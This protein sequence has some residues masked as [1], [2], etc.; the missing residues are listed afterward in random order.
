MNDLADVL[1]LPVM[2]SADDIR[3]IFQSGPSAHWHHEDDGHHLGQKKPTNLPWVAERIAGHVPP[4]LARRMDS[5]DPM[6]RY[7]FLQQGRGEVFPH[8]DDDY[9]GP[10]G[11]RALCSIILH[12]NDDCSGGETI[13]CG[14]TPA[15]YVPTGA[16]LVFPHDRLHEGRR[17]DKG[18]KLILKTDLFMMQMAEAS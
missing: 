14:R 13:F 6:M 17:V 8:R 4:A 15:P 7:Y 11:S 18:D 2:F 12:L 16:A 9:D 3:R 10:R 5:V 1:V